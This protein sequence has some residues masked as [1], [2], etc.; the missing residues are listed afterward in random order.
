MIAATPENGLGQLMGDGSPKLQSGSNHDYLVP[1]NLNNFRGETID[2]VLLNAL[3]DA[4]AEATGHLPPP[5]FTTSQLELGW[6]EMPKA[7]RSRI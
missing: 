6:D 7:Q 2:P 3:K 5:D 4:Y 1:L